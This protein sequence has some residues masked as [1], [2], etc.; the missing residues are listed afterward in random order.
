MMNKKSKT[1]K[2]T[3][4]QTGTTQSWTNDSLALS[5]QLAALHMASH[6]GHSFVV[7]VAKS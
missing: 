2:V 3:N 1:V 6:P 4:Q 5:L 7:E